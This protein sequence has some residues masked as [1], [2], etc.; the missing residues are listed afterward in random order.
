MAGSFLALMASAFVPAA[1]AGT[2]TANLSVTATISNNCSISTAAVAFG[3]YD[4]IVTNASTAASATGTINT[5]CTSGDAT[6]I[7][8]GQGANAGTG[9]T[10]AAPVRRMANGTNYLNY[11]LYTN[12]GHT[13]VFDGSTGVAVTGTGAQV[14]TS[15]YGSIPAGQNTLPAG[16][17]SDTV[18]A[19]VTF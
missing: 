9:S 14:G 12:S 1:I 16:S 13:T 11:S 17:Y 19:T 8:L 3:A 5:T 10:A 7:T 4:P 6:T 18:V 15:V 2:A